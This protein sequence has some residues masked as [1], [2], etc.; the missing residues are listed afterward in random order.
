MPPS[1]PPLATLSQPCTGATVEEALTRFEQAWSEENVQ[2]IKVLEQT[3]R[4]DEW[5]VRYEVSWKYS[6]FD[7]GPPSTHEAWAVLV[8]DESGYRLE[9]ATRERHIPA[10]FC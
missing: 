2:S 10:A 3:T 7:D 8:R 6:V 4:R 9:K 1:S 5:F